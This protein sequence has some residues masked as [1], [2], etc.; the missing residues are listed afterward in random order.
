M[1]AY[2]SSEQLHYSLTNI[3]IMH[4]YVIYN[5][6]QGSCMVAYKSSEQLHYSLTNTSIMY[7][8]IYMYV[9]IIIKCVSQIL[10]S[11]VKQNCTY[12]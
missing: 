2:K 8:Y 7:H 5:N 1:V 11:N 4:Q 12:I 6:V 10:M 9:Y 3:S